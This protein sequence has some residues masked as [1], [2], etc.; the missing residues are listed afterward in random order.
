MAKRANKVT[1]KD[2]ARAAGVSQS[3]VSMILNNYP[4]ASFSEETR[5]KVF[6]ACSRIGY[7]GASSLSSADKILLIVTPSC[8]NIFYA[9][10][11]EAA[12]QRAMEGGYVCM[13]LNT[14]RRQSIENSI[15]QCLS[16]MPFAGILFLYQPENLSLLT[17]IANIKPSIVVSDRNLDVNM[18][19]IEINSG[20][21][22]SIVADHLIELGHERVVYIASSIGHKYDTRIKR[23]DGIRLAYKAAGFDPDECVKVCTFETENLRPVGNVSEYKA[24]SSLT[25]LAIEKYPKTTAFIGNNDLICYGIV[26]A[27]C[28]QGYKIPKDYSVIGF[29][30]LNISDI[31]PISLTSVEHFGHLRARDAVDLLIKKFEEQNTALYDDSYSGSITRVEYQPKIVTRSS[32][33]APRGSHRK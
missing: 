19:M 5:R 29:D 22:G 26:D 23:L 32:T 18:D 21:L 3:T 20:K 7:K 25:S 28:K 2:V 9:K 33:G 24:G 1:S 12:Q 15:I 17:H 11:I 27:L 10:Q 13:I 30:N 4:N 8:E 14:F 16:S 31:E 6:E